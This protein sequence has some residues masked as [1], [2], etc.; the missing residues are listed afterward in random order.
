MATCLFATSRRSAPRSGCCSLL[1]WMDAQA[2]KALA[3]LVAG[4]MALPC[5]P[6]FGWSN[7]SVASYR[8]FEAMPEVAG[9]APVRAETLE[10]FLKDQE[11]AIETL[12]AR[13]EVW[14]RATIAAYA[15]RPDGLAF[16][17]MA[18]RS[19][20]ERR[21]AFLMAL[22]VS[23]D[24]K[25]ALYLQ[26]DP[27]ARLAAATVL[28]HSAVNALPEQAHSSYRFIAI[29]AGER[30]SALA[31]LAS[32]TDEPD[33]GLD[34]NL[35]QDSPSPSAKVY[36]FGPIPFGNP[37]LYFATQAPFHMGFY[38]QAWL[39]SKAA[40]F[41]QRTFPL[42][43]VHQY[44]GLAALAFQ[45]GHAY[46]GWRFAGLALHYVQDLTQPYHA[47][48]A[49]GDSTWT[50]LSANA[51][52]MAGWPRRKEQLIVL[53]SNRHLALEKYQNQTLLN[54]ARS[55]QY[56]AAQLA[57]RSATRD[58]AYPAW[59]ALYARDVVAREA[60]AAGAALASAIVAAM[61]ARLVSDPD[62]D[63]GVREAEIDLVAEMQ[64]QDPTR[65]GELDRMLADLLGRFG[66]HSRNA[67]RGILK[68]AARP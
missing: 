53:L 24:S 34:I 66:A 58:A 6:A 45:S 62:F 13:Q 19:D 22:R 36:G 35:W 3:L 14:A 50:M 56:S 32:A 10:A 54:D 9:A 38:H 59:D 40:P 43:R 12:L 65:I 25:F 18:G 64:R 28:P 2:L 42:L 48:L 21:Q 67:I 63:F 30:V 61:P 11:R 15:P 37:A 16:K 68:A 44:S 27:Q 7:H 8:A 47:S 23:P 41:I 39:I 5:A 1:L 57:L 33:Y 20:A 55:G 60:H 51:M 49:P 17:A 52:A 26:P 31:V 46:W 4:W 29:A